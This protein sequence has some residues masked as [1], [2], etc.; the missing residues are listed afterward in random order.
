MCFE[1]EYPRNKKRQRK[2]FTKKVKTA[3]NIK[4]N[5][6][7]CLFIYIP[8]VLASENI[9]HMRRTILFTYQMFLQAKTFRTCAELFYFHTRCSCKRKHSAHAQNYFIYIPDVLASEN[10][11]HMRRTIFPKIRVGIVDKKRQRR[12][13][14]RRRQ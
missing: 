12:R 11:P 8:D 1:N 14:R 13:R 10:I 7:N 4:M 2:F 3:E 5:S 9:P 6:V